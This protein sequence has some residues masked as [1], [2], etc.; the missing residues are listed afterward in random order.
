[1][2]SFS[3]RD[4]NIGYNEGRC[5]YGRFDY[6]YDNFDNRIRNVRRCVCRFI[7]IGIYDFQLDYEHL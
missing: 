4:N 2:L 6:Y 3:L 1:V 5:Y 7:K